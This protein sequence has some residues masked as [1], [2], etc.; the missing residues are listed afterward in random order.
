MT[1]LTEN[2][3]LKERLSKIAK[4]IEEADNRCM[5]IDGPVSKTLDEMTQKEISKIDRKSV[6]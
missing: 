5:A 6:V 1:V 2:K 4:I 3:K